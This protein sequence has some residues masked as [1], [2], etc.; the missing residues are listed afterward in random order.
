[1]R[2]KKI[3]TPTVCSFRHNKYSEWVRNTPMYDRSDNVGYVMSRQY[4]KKALYWKHAQRKNKYRFS[5][6][7]PSYVSETIKL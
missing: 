2:K 5:L 7:L 4:P 1:M 6:D 3:E